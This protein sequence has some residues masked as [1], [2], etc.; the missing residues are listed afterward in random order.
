[1][2]LLTSLQDPVALDLVDRPSK[3]SDPAHRIGPRQWY[4]VGLLCL[5]YTVHTLDRTIISVAIEPIK[6][7]FGLADRTMG[8]IVGLGY[9]MAF[10][11]AGIPL[12]TAIDRVNRRNLLAG[13][14]AL[15]STMTFLAGFVANGTQLMVSRALVGAAEAGSTPT[16][17]SLIADNFPH[18]RRATAIG[19]FSIG[20]GLGAVLSGAVGG[21]IA[22]DYGWRAVFFV[23]G[24]PGLLLAAIILFTVHEPRR[25]AMDAAPAI[26]T[27]L[28]S[29]GLRATLRLICSTPLLLSTY[30]GGG[31]LILAMS[32][33]GTWVMPF[34]V[35]HHG[36][37]LRQAGLTLA[38]AIGG[39]VA[40]GAAIGGVLSDRLARHSP[41]QRLNFC[42]VVALLCVPIGM[43]AFTA[44]SLPLVMVLLALWNIIIFCHAGPTQATIL[45]HVPPLSRG[46]AT[47]AY[48]VFV[49]LLG[50]GFGPYVIGL[51]SDIIG[52]TN[53]LRWSLAA[54]VGA[55]CLMSALCYLAGARSLGRDLRR[56]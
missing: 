48:Q 47:A 35:R 43:G 56:A 31:L 1:M 11:T 9:A 54:T 25:G 7:E 40:A 27:K 22:Q 52:G 24:V 16:A 34:L 12:G 41:A 4:L 19:L 14:V 13:L 29:A 46:T 53:S 21:A 38:V 6:R 3:P 51:S 55:T 37:N 45:N 50:Y 49:N 44:T 8:M 23:A 39:G 36:L 42:A 26:V 33:V 10:C 17:V 30:C 5:V 15:W 32:G 2:A 20:G 28:P 18:S